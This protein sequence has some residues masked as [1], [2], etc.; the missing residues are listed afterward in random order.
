MVWCQVC[1]A[2]SSSG[3]SSVVPVL[4]STTAG[5]SNGAAAPALQLNS[6][7]TGKC[8]YSLATAVTLEA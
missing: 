6:H 5:A 1:Q 4:H 8:I 3:H 2:C 7:N